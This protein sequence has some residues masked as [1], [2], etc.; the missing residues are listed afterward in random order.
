MV[1]F[2]S[3]V[4]LPTLALVCLPV[5]AFGQAWGNTIPPVEHFVEASHLCILA[6]EIDSVNSTAIQVSKTPLKLRWYR[7]T[8]AGVEAAIIV[9]TKTKVIYVVFRGTDG[10]HVDTF[11]DAKLRRVNITLPGL[12]GKNLGAVHEGFQTALRGVV[13]RLDA[14]LKSAIKAYPGYM[15]YFVGHSL[16]G[17]LAHLHGF[18]AAKTFLKTTNVRVITVGQPRVGN[19]TLRTSVEATKNLAVFRLVYEDG[20]LCSIQVFCLAASISVS[21]AFRLLCRQMLLPEFRLRL[22]R[23]TATPATSL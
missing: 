11:I 15:V 1:N 13:S 2:K 5:P 12:A 6:Y 9:G 23:V 22:S 16:G 19:R 20:E 14:A 18:Y 4:L 10:E 17:A 21:S 7:E 8:S 3:L